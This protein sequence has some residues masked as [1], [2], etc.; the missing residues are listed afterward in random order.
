MALMTT[1]IAVPLTY[2]GRRF[3]RLNGILATGSGLL[4]LCFGLFLVYELG[5]VGGLFSRHPHWI[6][7]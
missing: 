1:A 7:S 3:S 6:P 5:F 2:G 4:S